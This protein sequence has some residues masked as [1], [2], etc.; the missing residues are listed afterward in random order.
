MMNAFNQMGTSGTD[1]LSD[2]GTSST[3]IGGAGDDTLNA[4]AAS[5]LY[6]GSGNDTFVINHTMVA[7]LQSSMGSGGNTARLAR[8]DG[9]SGVDTLRLQ[10]A[11][12]TLDLTL[13]A[14]QSGGSVDGGSR[15]SS[16]EKI[17]LT[18]SGNHTLKLTA[19]DVL[20]SVEIDRVT[21]LR[22]LQVFGDTGDALHILGLHVRHGGDW[23][24]D[25]SVYRHIPSN[26]Q[27]QVM[28]D[29]RVSI[30]PPVL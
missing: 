19:R 22:L 13:I 12:I 18:G 21:K 17:D 10:G 3:L 28:G 26:F 15:L 11:D 25:G 24:S 6:G 14:N 1:T 27:I 7:A 5:I 16:I 29:V 4:T 20:D 23:T 30:E 8:I 2:G 9:G